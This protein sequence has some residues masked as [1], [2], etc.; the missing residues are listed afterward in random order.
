MPWHKPWLPQKQT[1]KQRATGIFKQPAL[2]VFVCSAAIHSLNA[3]CFFFFPVYVCVC[4]CFFMAA[5]YIR[6]CLTVQRKFGH[7]SE[8]EVRFLPLHSQ[9]DLRHH[10]KLSWKASGGRMLTLLTLKAQYTGLI[11]HVC[12]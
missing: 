6:L 8:K 5:L 11:F 4:V 3:H 10:V 2:L 7:D 12:T 1:N 9:G